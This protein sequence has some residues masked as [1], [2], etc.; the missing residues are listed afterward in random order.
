MDKKKVTFQKYKESESKS[1]TY[2]WGERW[3]KGKD[4][5]RSLNQNIYE[6]GQKSLKK[7]DMLGAAGWLL[8]RAKCSEHQGHLV[9][10]YLYIHLM[11]V[12]KNVCLF[13]LLEHE[14]LLLAVQDHV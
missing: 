13:P 6:L 9:Y 14:L 4:Y 5:S 12:Y 1:L 7:E 11:Y 8:V 3:G 2:S 10:V